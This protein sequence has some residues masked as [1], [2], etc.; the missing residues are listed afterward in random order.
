M[1]VLGIHL[2]LQNDTTAYLCY[3]EIFA[4][5]NGYDLDN[6]SIPLFYHQVFPL[7][8]VPRI[9]LQVVVFVRFVS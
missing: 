1:I 5:K 7:A 3:Q 9:L 6:V 8:H 2:A 4:N